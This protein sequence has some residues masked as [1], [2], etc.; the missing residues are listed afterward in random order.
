MMRRRIEIGE[1]L[2]QRVCSGLHLGLLRPG[3]RVA[4]AREVA[5][6]LGTDYRVVVAAARAL[7]RER[8]L[9]VRP[10]A[11]IFVARETEPARAGALPVPDVGLLNLL[12]EEVMSGLSAQSFPERARRCLQTVRLRAACL[13][14][15][16]DQRE[17]LCHELRAHYGLDCL[18]VEI[19]GLEADA[20]SLRTAD[21]LV[22]TSYH[23]GDVRRLAE[24]LG[25]PCILVT[26]DPAQRAEIARLLVQKPVYF[27]G[28]DPRWARKA[29]LIWGGEAGAAANLRHVTLGIDP[30]GAIPREA[31]VMVM[32]GARRRLAGHRL[33]EQALPQ[34]G[35]SRDSARQILAFVVQAN[36]AAWLGVS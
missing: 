13:E 32:P 1:A 35:F 10:R 29:R 18:G 2:R 27:V 34:R 7:E 4:S 6:Q 11:G 26:L 23:A 22:S 8:L 5:K 16:E 33:L 36:V 28:T 14:C 21:L 20:P 31:A 24:A 30:L 19:E 3:D 9:H 17:A 15:N 25:K 12:V